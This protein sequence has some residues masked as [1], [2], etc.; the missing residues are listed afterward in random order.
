MSDYVCLS[1]CLCFSKRTTN[2]LCI[3]YH[4][5]AIW[6]LALIHSFC[7]YSFVFL[8]F[9]L[10]LDQ[11]SVSFLCLQRCLSFCGGAVILPV[12]KSLQQ[13]EIL[14]YIVL[15]PQQSKTLSWPFQRTYPAI[16]V[17][18]VNPDFLDAGC[19]LVSQQ[20]Q[21]LNLYRLRSKQERT[22][23]YSPAYT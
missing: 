18:Q 6:G 19:C 8:Y 17:K 5:L 10:C 21:I 14:S 15:Y 3:P 23:C 13:W 9:G 12:S 2:S 7:F 11:Q 4:I 20:T 22:W 1:V 16:Y